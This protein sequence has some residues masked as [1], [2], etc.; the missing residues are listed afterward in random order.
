VFSGSAHDAEDGELPASRL[1]WTLRLHHCPDDDC[2]VHVL[3]G[4]PDVASGSFV[5]PDH[6]YP[7]HLEL[8]LTATDQDGGVETTSLELGPRTVPVTFATE[9]GGL[10]LTAASDQAARLRRSPAR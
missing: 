8:Q 3:Q 7:S 6:S 1:D 4:F 5:A 2:H 9:P 10:L